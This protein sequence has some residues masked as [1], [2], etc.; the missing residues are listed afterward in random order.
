M[1]TLSHEI[2][3]NR[4]RDDVFAFAVVPENQP[5]W[6]PAGPVWVEKLDSQPLGVG[7][8]YRGKWKR[9]GKAEWTFM[10]FDPPRQFT[11]DARVS[12][13]R[14]IHRLRFDD[15]DGTTRFHQNLE[16]ETA[17]ALEL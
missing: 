10:T 13:I 17:K 1:L 12:G 11:H 16:V 8:H 5:I 4:P 6:D 3:I 15:R 7:S 14:M 2:V 9:F